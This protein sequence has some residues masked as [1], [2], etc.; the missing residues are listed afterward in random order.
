MSRTMV[1][2]SM[3]GALGLGAIPAGR[4]AAQ[5]RVVVPIVIQAPRAGSPA[6]TGPTTLRTTTRTTSPQPGVTTTRVTV[7]NTTGSGRAV[8]GPPATQTLSTVPPGTPSVLVTVDR[9]LGPDGSGAPGQTR[10]I[11]RDVSQS[12]RTLGGPAPVST[13]STAGR[14]QETFI[15]T[16]EAPIDAPIVIL[17]P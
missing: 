7:T 5:S 13:L 8:G 6:P 2:V 9:R 10:V 16:S 4:A 3:L 14:G 12:G 11:V 17:A 15:I 1:V